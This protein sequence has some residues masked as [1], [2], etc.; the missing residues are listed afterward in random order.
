[1]PDPISLNSQITGEGPPLL[2]VHGLFGQGRNWGG[3]ARQLGR[4]FTVHAVDLRNHGASPRATPMTYEAMAADLAAY[5]EAHQLSPAYI[6][7]HSMGGKAAMLLALQN[8]ELVK[9]LLVADVAPVPYS[10]DFYQHLEAMAAIDLSALTSRAEADAILGGYIEERGVR[11]FLLSNLV[12]DK[13][14]GWAWLIDRGNI[15]ADI[16]AI[17]D[18][19]D[20]ADQQFGRP[21]LFLSGGQSDYVTPDMH[22]AIRALFP[23]AGFSV[24]G[25]AGHWLHA[26]Q[27]QAFLE[28]VNGFMAA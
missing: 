15:A 28:A 27:P 4:R 10:H 8:P 18:W 20:I 19:P 17:T 14:A 25:N 6:V 24:I 26:D 21:T 7:G 16:E 2:I 22:E 1:M 23:E 9:R 3:L 11:D 12:R 5:I 13:E